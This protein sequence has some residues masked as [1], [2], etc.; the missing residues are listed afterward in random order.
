MP[1]ITTTELGSHRGLM[2]TPSAE[3]LDQLDRLAL[4]FQFAPGEPEP[5]MTAFEAYTLAREACWYR[6][7]E[8]DDA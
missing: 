3:Q 4:R 7:E 6:V 1:E 2:A 8:A 5:R